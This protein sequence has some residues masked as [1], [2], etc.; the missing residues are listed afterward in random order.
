MGRSREADCV[1]PDSSELKRPAKKGEG[2]VEVAWGH[3]V[4]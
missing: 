2:T 4:N 1:T 3:S